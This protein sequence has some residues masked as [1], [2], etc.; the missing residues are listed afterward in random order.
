MISNRGLSL[1]PR[2][3]SR[4][5][6]EKSSMT[7]T[8]LP[9]FNSRSTRC[10]PMKPAPPVTRI[11]FICGIIE[12]LNRLPVP[13]FNSNS[14][15]RVGQRFRQLLAKFGRFDQPGVMRAGEKTC[16]DQNGRTGLATQH[17][18][19]TRPLHAE[20]VQT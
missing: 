2:K 3:L 19:E 12:P 11:C 14:F 17:A 20:V 13:W 4:L 16:F 8:V 5:P 18:G 1:T 10:E 6:V 9:S 7:T 15:Q